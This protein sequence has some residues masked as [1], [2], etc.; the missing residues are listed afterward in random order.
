MRV[1]ILFLS[2][3]LLTDTGLAEIFTGQVVGVIDGDTIEVL[4]DDQTERIRLNGI[5]CPGKGQ[6]YRR[7]AKQFTSSLVFGKQVIIQP[8]KQ[9]RHGRT[10]ADV[11]VDETNVSRE[12]LRVG[13]RGGIANIHRI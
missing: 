5:D 3:L 8:Y 4:Y 1:L 9:D 6:P 11:F 12:L 13:W 2:T 10:V 7:K